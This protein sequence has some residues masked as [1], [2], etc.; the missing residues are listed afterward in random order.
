MRAK[1]GNQEL[2]CYV[3]LCFFLN[4]RFIVCWLSFQPTSSTPHSTFQRCLET[5]SHKTRI[6][7]SGYIALSMIA[8]GGGGVGGRKGCVRHSIVGEA[9]LNLVEKR[10][11]NCIAICEPVSLNVL[12]TP[13]ANFHITS[14]GTTL[15]CFFFYIDPKIK[16]VLRPPLTHFVEAG[17]NYVKQAF[18]VAKF[19]RNS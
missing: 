10:W 6:D 5:K 9:R 7:E 19:D 14:L 3:N 2:V 13:M 16:P 12:L 18:S 8:F 1:P 11:Y 17:S 15:I 4:V